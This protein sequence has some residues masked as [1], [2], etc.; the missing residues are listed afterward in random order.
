MTTR[1]SLDELARML[2]VPVALVRQ[3]VDKL[4]AEELLTAE[5]F[6]YGDRNW[7]VAPSDVKRVSQWIEENEKT[8]EVQGAA[9]KRRV[10][11]K[12]VMSSGNGTQSTEET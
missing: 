12:R 1:F 6:V 8:G 4:S 10:T 7:R 3:A 2:N 11:R 9:P 5:S